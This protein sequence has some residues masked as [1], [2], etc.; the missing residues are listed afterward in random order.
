MIIGLYVTVLGTD[1]RYHHGFVEETTRLK[2]WN[3][4]IGICILRPRRPAGEEIVSQNV[5]SI[6][7]LGGGNASDATQIEL[8]TDDVPVII[9]PVSSLTTDAGSFPDP[10]NPRFRVHWLYRSIRLASRDMFMAVLDGL[11]L[12]AR[13]EESA[14][15]RQLDALSSGP[16]RNTR[17]NIVAVRSVVGARL[18]YRYAARTLLLISRLLVRLRRYEEMTFWVEFDGVRFGKGSIRARRPGTIE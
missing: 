8:D 14:F 4:Q 7:L 3:K 11:S 12:A 17:L 1:T 6:N 5:S 18:T 10:D 16:Q 13:E 2:L 15:C 9:T